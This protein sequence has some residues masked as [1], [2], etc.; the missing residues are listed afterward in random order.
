MSRDVE[1][2]GSGTRSPSAPWSPLSSRSPLHGP[3]DTLRCPPSPHLPMVIGAT[4]PHNAG[5]EVWSD[6]VQSPPSCGSY[7]LKKFDAYMDLNPWIWTQIHA[8]NWGPL[9]CEAN[10]LPTMLD[11]LSHPL[12]SDCRPCRAKPNWGIYVAESGRIVEFEAHHSSREIAFFCFGILFDSLR[13]SLLKS[14][15]PPIWLS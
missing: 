12:V 14:K 6:Q 9:D 1:W 4:W 5:W 2:H 11:H 8:S 7:T 15:L 3:I 10:T 13:Q